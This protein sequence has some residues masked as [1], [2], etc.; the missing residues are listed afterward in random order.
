MEYRVNEYGVSEQYVNKPGIKSVN[1]IYISPMSNLKEN[2]GTTGD[3]IPTMSEKVE[4]PAEKRDD[5]E[6]IV[7]ENSAYHSSEKTALDSKSFRV[8]KSYRIGMQL[9]VLVAIC[10]LTY[11]NA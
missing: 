4:Y 1:Y 2:A 9:I 6:L 10:Y 11:T 5:R 7:A 3:A 8:P